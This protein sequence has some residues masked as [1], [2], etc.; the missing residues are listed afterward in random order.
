MKVRHH[1]KRRIRIVSD[2]NECGGGPHDCD[3]VCHNIP[4]SYKCSCEDGYTLLSDNKTCEGKKER[5]YIF[6][7]LHTK[8]LNM[9]ITGNSALDISVNILHDINT[10]STKCCQR[11]ITASNNGS[12]SVSPHLKRRI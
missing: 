6:L 9:N 4:G 7:V 2:I 10:Q 5:I 8:T 12:T 1:L 3:Q 11:C